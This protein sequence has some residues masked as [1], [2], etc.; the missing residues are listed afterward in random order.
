MSKSSPDSAIFME[1]TAAEV[2]KKIKQAFCPP[3]EV[4]G[5]PC[6]A[7]MGMIIFPWQG[8]VTVPRSEA[9]GG[10]KYALLLALHDLVG[11]YAAVLCSVVSRPQ[12]RSC[13]TVHRWTLPPCESADLGQSPAKRPS[14]ISGALVSL[15]HPSILRGVIGLQPNQETSDAGAVR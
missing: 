12:G 13:C 8:Q 14:F 5:N 2:N 7:Y 9:N 1:D 11:S 10:P 4:V 15:T 3:Q 6:I